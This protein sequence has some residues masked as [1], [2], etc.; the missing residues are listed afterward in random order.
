MKKYLKVG[1]AFDGGIGF[2]VRHSNEQVRIGTHAINS[3]DELVEMNKELL[4]ALEAAIECG[5]VPTSSAE[6]GG[7]MRY[8]RQAHVA[9]KIRKAISKAKGERPSSPDALRDDVYVAGGK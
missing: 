1:S 6:E 9:D 7:A 4:A 2:S 3:H 8:V 5:M